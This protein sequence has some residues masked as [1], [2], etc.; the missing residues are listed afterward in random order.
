M[1]RV[2]PPPHDLTALEL[3]ALV[4]G[5][6]VSPT[7]LTRH[8]LHRIGALDGELDAFVT[9][10]EDRALEAARAAER[11]LAAGNAHGPL[12]G[13]PVAVTDVV[14]I[15]GVRC[16]RGSAAYHDDVAERDDRVVERLKAAGMVILGTLNVGELGLPAY[17]ENR[18]APPTRNPWSRRHSPGGASGGA[19]AAVAAGLVP[20]AH[21][22]D[23]AVAASAC[24]IVGLEPT[25]GH[26]AL[27]R[28]AR[29]AAALLAAMA[30][31]GGRG[32]GRRRLRI[33]TPSKLSVHPDCEDAV[34]RA[35]ARLCDA[36]HR[37][38]RI[39]LRPDPAAAEAYALTQA[40]Y[41]ANLP[42]ADETLLM[43]FTRRARELGRRMSGIELH[44]ALTAFTG[45]DAVLSRYDAVL[46]PALAR[47]PVLLGT[48]TTDPDE[49][50]NVA[51]MAAYSPFAPFYAIADL[52]AISVPAGFGDDGLPTGVL[53]GGRSGEEATLV[54]LAAEL[55]AEGPPANV[56]SAWWGAAVDA[57]GRT[58]R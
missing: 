57:S 16:T 6:E 37:V 10:T 22:A 54:A 14:G 48:F 28:T 15:A 20:L 8:F 31:P 44:S 41:A 49:A 50:V 25:R 32:P 21:G 34:E 33:A 3:G 43:P 27:A 36:G 29:D 9:V 7:E 24:G 47:P 53:L 1:R 35:A 13:V 56:R 42:V 11:A 46:T 17:T 30:G 58:R 26:S 19:A 39:Y 23:A 51:R 5:G 38:E 2:T 55:E 52:P 4:R 45:L 18:I 12:H 40:L